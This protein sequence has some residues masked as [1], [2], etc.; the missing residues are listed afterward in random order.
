MVAGAVSSATRGNMRNGHAGNIKM[1]RRCV[2][3]NDQLLENQETTS[4]NDACYR[5]ATARNILLG[6]NAAYS[7]FFPLFSFRH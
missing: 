3:R 2:K 6:V 1:H 7:F 5:M 4:I